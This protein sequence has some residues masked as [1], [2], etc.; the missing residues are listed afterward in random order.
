MLAE[1]L[2]ISDS[3]VEKQLSKLKSTHQ[4][5]R[6]GPDKGGHWEVVA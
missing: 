6:I 5:K 1:Q 4:I 2:E 3:T